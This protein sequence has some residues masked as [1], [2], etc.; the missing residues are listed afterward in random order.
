MYTCISVESKVAYHYVLSSFEVM[1]KQYKV[2]NK[3]AL[4]QIFLY[5]T[6]HVPY[7]IWIINV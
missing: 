5:F 6:S 2:K 3:H 1:T 7:Y 4:T